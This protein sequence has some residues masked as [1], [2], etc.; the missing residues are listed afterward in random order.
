[1]F[2][3]E[4]YCED[5]N[6]AK[7]HHALT[8]LVHDLKTVPVVNAAQ[9]ANGT[10]IAK[11]DGTVLNLLADHLKSSRATTFSSKQAQEFLRT[12]GF[13]SSSSSYLTASAVAAGLLRK[14]KK[15][16]QFLVRS[17]KS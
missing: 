14:T 13:S 10:L 9:G 1:M 11:G 2:R 6:L 15:S 4:C 12:H 8:G 17:A 7:V 16:G 5:K 3:V